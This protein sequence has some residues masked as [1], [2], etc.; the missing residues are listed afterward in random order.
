MY[1]AMV[2][3]YTNPTYQ[4]FPEEGGKTIRNESH[5]RMVCSLHRLERMSKIEYTDKPVNK[6][7]LIRYRRSDVLP[8]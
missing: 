1:I 2:G 4:R 5:M 7:F 3:L 6:I 8:L